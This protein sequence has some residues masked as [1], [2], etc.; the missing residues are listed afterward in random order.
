[1]FSYKTQFPISFDSIF[2]LK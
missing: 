2:H 1:M